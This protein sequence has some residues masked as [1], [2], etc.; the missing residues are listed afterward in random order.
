MSSRWFACI[1]QQTAETL[2]LGL[3]WSSSHVVAG[4]NG[5]R[6]RRGRTPDVR[7]T[8]PSSILKARPAKG[9]FTSAGSV[10]LFV[11]LGVHALD[12]RN[13]QRRGQEI[14]NG[15]EQLLHAFVL[16]RRTAEDGNHAAADGRLADDRAQIWSAGIS[17][18]SRYI[19][20]ISSSKQ[21]YGI[22]ELFPV[23][24]GKI[25]HVLGDGLHAHILTQIV[26][27]RRRH[28]CR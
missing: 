2:A 4:L 14:D 19:S 1:V 12:G 17:S 6:S 3:G 24:V 22:D 8:G 27:D 10:D 26:V 15:V 25:R 11:R 13:I 23:L 20:M 21:R 9:P 28:P 18:P 7:R 5:S 16:V